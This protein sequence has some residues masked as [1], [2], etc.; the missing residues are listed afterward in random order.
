M[1]AA[2]CRRTDGSQIR[3]CETIDGD[4]W[5]D[6]GRIWSGGQTYVALSRGRRIEQ[7]H[8]GRRI[9][10]EDVLVEKHAMDFLAEGDSP[11]SL[12]EIRS[13]ASV[14]YRET[15]KIRREAET[16]RKA[17]EASKQQVETLL[18]ELRNIVTTIRNESQRIESSEKKISVA[19]EQARKTNWL[20]RLLGKF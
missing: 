20:R 1:P 12:D 10:E 4:V 6:L 5:V 16:E 19:L 13:K 18:L 9:T 14:I 7:L 15:T 2:R 8:L 17:A 3:A 11:V